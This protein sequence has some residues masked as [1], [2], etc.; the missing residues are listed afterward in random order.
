[1][2]ICCS[3]WLLM[4]AQFGLRG[5]D[6][7]TPIY[8]PIGLDETKA[9]TPSYLSV[10]KHISRTTYRNCDNVACDCVSVLLW[11][12]CEQYVMYFRFC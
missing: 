7:I 12:Y 4:N 8:R 11:R 2:T 1:M 6:A 10:N 3:N 9:R 5:C